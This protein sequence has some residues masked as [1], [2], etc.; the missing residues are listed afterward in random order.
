MSNDNGDTSDDDLSDD[1][2]VQAYKRLHLKWVKESQVVGKLKERI[3]ALL[4]DENC[5]MLTISNLKEE[6]IPL[7]YKLD[8]MTKDVRMLHSETES[9]N[10]ILGV[11][12]LS[13]DMKGIG[14]SGESPNSKTVFV[15]PI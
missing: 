8:G 11:G 5:P 6:V 15:P 10:E 2:L 12:K 13:K 14:Y 4:Q 3:E 1:A 7:N 9:H